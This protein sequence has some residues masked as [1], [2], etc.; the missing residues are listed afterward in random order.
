MGPIIIFDK[1]TLQSLSLDE[2]VWLENY[3]LNVIVPLFYVE[4]LADLSRGTGNDGRQIETIIGELAKKT[5][6]QGSAPNVHHLR[7]IAGDL[8]GQKVEMTNRPIISGG[9]PKMTPDGKVGIH[10]STPP[11]ALAMERWNKGQFLE[12]EKEFA[13]DWRLAL[14]NLSFDWYIGLI[15]NIVPTNLKLSSHQDVK[16]FVDEFVKGKYKQLIYLA[17]DVLGVPD[18]SRPPVIERWRKDWLPF[19]EFAPY[20]AYVLRIDLFFY[21]CMMLGLESKERPSHK[22]DLAYLY[23]LPFCH[24]FVSNDKLHKRIAPLFMEQDQMFVSGFDLKS[25][26]HLIDEHFSQLPDEIKEL[27]TMKFAVY[28]PKDINSVIHQTWDKYCPAWRKH[29]G[30]RETNP[31]AH[32]PSDPELLKKLKYEEENSIPVNLPPDFSSDQAESIVFSRMVAVKKGKWRILPKEVE[33]AA[34]NNPG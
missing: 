8:L 5:P 2:S 34:R 15:K 28:P 25:G 27:G 4:T 29:L 31:E 12:I 16:K 26:L 21:L 20:A 10:Y 3:Y 13:K 18:K 23:Y 1:S 14:S 6:V 33:E 19:D 22:I 24:V 9:K 17:L 32:L 30:E 7:L 11:E